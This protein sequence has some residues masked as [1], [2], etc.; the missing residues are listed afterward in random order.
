M[1][2]NLSSSLRL[3]GEETQKSVA[4]FLLFPVKVH[5]RK[6]FHGCMV[7][8]RYI[9]TKP[10]KYPGSGEGVV[11]FISQNSIRKRTNFNHRRWKYSAII[12]KDL[13]WQVW[14]KLHNHSFKMKLVPKNFQCPEFDRHAHFVCFKP[15]YNF[16]A[17]LIQK[18]KMFKLKFGSW[19][20]NLNMQNSVVIFT[21]FFRTENSFWAKLVKNSKLSV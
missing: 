8:N 10:W 20:S 18:N 4:A 6:R 17:N 16:R 2:S 1:S 5:L 3:Y 13:F 21:F 19:T 12:Q 7:Y 11:H 9:A 14:S 15:K